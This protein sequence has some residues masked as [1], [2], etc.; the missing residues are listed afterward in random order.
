M[1]YEFCPDTILLGEDLECEIYDK[2]TDKYFC[3]LVSI[4]I[5]NYR[6]PN[7]VVHSKVRLKILGISVGPVIDRTFDP[8]NPRPVPPDSPCDPELRR[9][10][11][12]C[13]L[14]ESWE[15]SFLFGIMRVKV[16]IYTCADGRFF[17]S[18]WK[19]SFFGIPLPW[20]ERPTFP[21]PI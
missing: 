20:R 12:K 3:G 8:N 16:C 15:I 7:E 1:A 6:C 5:C 17:Y 4:E 18:R 11:A 2:W 9:G 13:E 21:Y 19:T 14:F 10:A